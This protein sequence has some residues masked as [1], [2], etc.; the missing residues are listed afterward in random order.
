MTVVKPEP[1]AKV[2][3]EPEEVPSL[4]YYAEEYRKRNRLGFGFGVEAGNYSGN[5]LFIEYNMTPSSQLH[6]QLAH[7]SES[8]DLGTD[9]ISENKLQR[10]MTALS[11]RYF[12]VDSGL[13]LGCG[14]GSSYFE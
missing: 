4:W 2:E 14:L 11:Y 9:S 13:Y 1:E 12:M 6:L 3:P 7:N 8:T 5:D 10:K